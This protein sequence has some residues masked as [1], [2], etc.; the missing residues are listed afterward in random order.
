[1]RENI[2]NISHQQPGGGE[3]EGDQRKQPKKVVFILFQ[4]CLLS[5]GGWFC[6]SDTRVRE[7]VQDLLGDMFVQ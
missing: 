2:S 5:A 3:E 1:M 7:L 6:F 4:L